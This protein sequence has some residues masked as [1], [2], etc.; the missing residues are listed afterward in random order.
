[1]KE[2]VE[3]AKNPL[4]IVRFEDLINKDKKAQEMTDL[5]RFVFGIADATGTNLER[6]VEA[7]MGQQGS[8]YKLKKTSG[9]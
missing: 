7:A 2:C 9:K 6:R 3:D 4:Y 1:M 8:V 5:F